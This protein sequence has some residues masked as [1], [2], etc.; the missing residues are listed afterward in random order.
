[1]PLVFFFVLNTKACV[2]RKLMSAIMGFDFVGCRSGDADDA[3]SKCILH[4]FVQKK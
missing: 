3:V 1:L 2:L 4:Y